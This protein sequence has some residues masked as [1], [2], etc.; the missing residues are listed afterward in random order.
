MQKKKITYEVT[1]TAVQDCSWLS[2]DEAKGQSLSG[3]S[4]KHIEKKA[5]TVNGWCLQSSLLWNCL[6]LCKGE[7]GKEVSPV[8]K[9][10]HLCL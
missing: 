7:R 4:E 10:G 2:V 6:L 1:Y 3:E 8:G 9:M 5:M